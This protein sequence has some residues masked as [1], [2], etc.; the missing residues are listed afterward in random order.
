[1][2]A[3]RSYY[4]SALVWEKGKGLSA[5]SD[6]GWRV[7]GLPDRVAPPPTTRSVRIAP[8]LDEH[9]E[10]LRSYDSDAEG[11]ALDQKGGWLVSF[12]GA[13]RRITSYNVCYTKLLR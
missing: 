4:V 11:A 8:L 7:M 5:V 1:M 10:H 6:R 9:G 2:Y 3:I 13:H 12:E